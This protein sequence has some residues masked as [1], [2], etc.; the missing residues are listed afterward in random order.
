MKLYQRNNLET[1]HLIWLHSTECNSINDNTSIEAQ[2]RAIINRLN[3]LDDISECQK[4]IERTLD[5]D[6]IV[7]IVDD[8]WSQEIISYARELQRISSIYVYENKKSGNIS[9]TFGSDHKVK[10]FFVNIDDLTKQLASDYDHKTRRIYNQ[11]DEPISIN[12]LNSESVLDQSST[13]LNGHFI[14]SHMLIDILLRMPTNDADKNELIDICER[15]YE[16]NV[17]RLMTLNEFKHTYSSEQAILWYTKESFLYHLLNKA[18]RIHDIDLLFLFRFFI[19][20]IHQQLKQ[21]QCSTKMRVYRGQLMSK[22]ELYVL[23]KSI[24]QLISMNSFFS[25]SGDRDLA[26]FFLGNVSASDASHRILFEIDVDPQVDGI[27]PF[28]DVTAYSY[29]PSE[30]EV[31]MMVGS[32]FR[33]ESIRKESQKDG[34]VIHVIQMRLCSD[35][36]DSTKLMYEIL[37]TEARIEEIGKTSLLDFGNVLIDVG[38]FNEAEKYFHR[39]LGSL[40]TNHPNIADCYHGLGEINAAR[41]DYQ[42]SLEWLQKA[43]RV[44]MENLP[45]NHDAIASSYNRIGISFEGKGDYV[46]A[47]DSYNKA[48]VIWKNID[49][50]HPRAAWCLN[51]IGVVYQKEKKYYESLEYQQRSL[52]IAKKSLP[53]DHPNI[54]A[55]VHNIGDVYSSF[56]QFETALEYYERALKSFQKSRPSGHPNIAY[57]LGSMGLLYEK[58]NE[59]DKS[60]DY[61]QQ[62]MSI[63]QKIMPETHP[64]RVRIQQSLEQVI[65]KMES[66]HKTSH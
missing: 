46:S 55:S 62:S 11:I 13:Q 15:E 43:L 34:G 12:I 66:A 29:F 50:N 20:D 31:L 9:Q 42:S 3:I 36:N 40:P 56:N 59:L 27:K 23:E 26:L 1:F 22:K 52:R 48:F 30:K 6:R 25:T 53:A 37:K 65:E 7:I 10:G 21:L 8:K 51:N 2:F 49:E 57:T 14:F 47:V 44:R 41:G 58:T 28:A 64:D 45:F 17:S 54:A 39:L 19:N 4:Y 18:L 32:I 60:L 61:L 63:Y 5:T 33:L 38:K 16:G 35:N 24:G